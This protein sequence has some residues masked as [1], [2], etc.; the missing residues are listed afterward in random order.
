MPH[1]INF[2]RAWHPISLPQIAQLSANNP[3]VT[4]YLP[5]GCG[6][7]WPF[8]NGATQAWGALAPPV[9]IPEP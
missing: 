3:D 8:I 5:N 1:A 6:G 9:M 4:F 7:T 2:D